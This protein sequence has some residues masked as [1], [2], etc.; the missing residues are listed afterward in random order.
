MAELVKQEI[1][2]VGEGASAQQESKDQGEVTVD[3][4][5]KTVGGHKSEQSQEAERIQKALAKMKRMD[6]KLND[7]MKVGGTVSLTHQHYISQIVSRICSEGA[8][9]KK[10]KKIA[11]TAVR[12]HGLCK[13]SS[14]P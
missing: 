12:S 11:R 14:K 8:G 9:R 2:R 13:R 1:Q 6:V 7:L 10:T 3:S 5:G 4:D